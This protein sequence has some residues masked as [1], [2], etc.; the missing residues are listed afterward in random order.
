MNWTP[1]DSIRRGI[2]VAA[3]IIGPLL[4]VLSIAIN[5]TPPGDSMRADFDA[6]AAR[7][8]LIVA[9][10]ML[11]TIGFLLVLAAFAGATQALR[12]RGGTLGTVG[13]VLSIL[14]IVGFSFSNA[15]GFTLAELAQLP[16]RDAAFA[17]AMAITS[18]DTAG[19]VGTIG[20]VFEILGQVGILLVI[21]GLIRARV[22]RIWILL[23]VIVGIV[24]NAAIG[25]MVTTLIADVLLLAA[26]TWVA[27]RLARSS[28]ET[29]LGM[30]ASATASPATAAVPV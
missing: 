3:L 1:T 13:A 12:A 19:L 4:L 9:E 27:V 23:L 15:N 16:D 11:E 26:S 20:M 17:T 22:V 18:S 14:G 29:W 2:V 28:H 6:M 5:F 25:L 10:A 8:G 24:V 21:C 30:P 7:S